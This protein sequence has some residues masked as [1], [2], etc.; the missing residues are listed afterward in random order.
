MTRRSTHSQRRA[1]PLAG[2]L[3][4]GALPG[5]LPAQPAEGVAVDGSYLL[6][7]PAD[8]VRI[9]LRLAAQGDSPQ[10]ALEALR[11][12]AMPLGALLEAGGV[13][14]ASMFTADAPP[15]P[16]AAA[17]G[18][19]VVREIRAT[20]PIAGSPRVLN[21]LAA[22]PGV[23]VTEV[24]SELADRERIRQQAI[25]RATAEA[26]GKAVIAARQLGFTVGSVREIRVE[27]RE[28]T[29]PASIGVE[30]KVSV[31]YALVPASSRNEVLAIAAARAAAPEASPGAAPVTAA[32]AAPSTADAATTG[33][34]P[35]GAS[36]ADD[37]APVAL[38]VEIVDASYDAT[39]RGRF[40][41]AV[42]TIWREVVPVPREQRLRSGRRY[43]GTITAGIFGGYRM[44]LTGVPRILKVEPVP[45]P[46]PAA[47]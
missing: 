21:A 8:R 3:A 39:G 10:T 22:Q 14:P 30:A 44:Q 40:T 11:V 7:V 26:A 32:T 18:W 35:T 2:L 46:Q 20:L 29:G 5:P 28:Q 15:A 1:L 4:L 31:R 33:P 37:S 27:D 9:A 42:G 34:T 19:M 6:Q 13:E 17:T 16:A 45:T 23:T 24:V 38:A 47:R 43:A 25:E 36:T 12:A 41:T